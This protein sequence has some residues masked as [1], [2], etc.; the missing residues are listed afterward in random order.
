VRS[1]PFTKQTKLT[2]IAYLSE[3]GDIFATFDART[4]DS[5]N[6]SFGIELNGQRWFV[7][8]AGDPADSTSFLLHEDRVG[9]LLNAQRLAQTVAHTALPFLNGVTQS[10]WGPMLI[11]DWV[12]G[13]LLGASVARRADPQSAFQRFRRLPSDALT[14]AIDSVIDVHLELCGVG[15]VACDFYDGSIIYDFAG[16]R[17]WLVDLD[18]YHMGAFSNEMGRMFG[19]SRFMAP[20][21]FERGAMI[22]ER[23][24]VFNI[25]RAISVFFGDGDLSRAEFRGSETQYQTMLRACSSDPAA[26]FP[27]IAELA[28]SWRDGGGSLA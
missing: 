13:E 7:K 5:G 6:V 18:N 11:Y 9:L 8:T 15:W 4:Q 16:D 19:S 14:S 23:T 12:V 26:R 21:E 22:N 25:G 27:S 17:T 1:W 3:L 28:R 20:E 10:A 2:P 24:T